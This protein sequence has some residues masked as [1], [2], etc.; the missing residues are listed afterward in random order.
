MC[1]TPEPSIP[2]SS[3]SP[4]STNAHTRLGSPPLTVTI[5]P[6]QNINECLHG[7]FGS[8]GYTYITITF[9]E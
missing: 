3:G 6:P 2:A 4:P 5:G 9:D 1:M 8:L 7:L